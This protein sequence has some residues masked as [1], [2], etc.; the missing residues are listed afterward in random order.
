MA[1]AATRRPAAPRRRTRRKSNAGTG[2]DT[3]WVC[4][5]PQP[6]RA[7]PKAQTGRDLVAFFRASPLVGVELQIERDRPAG[8]EVDLY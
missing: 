6:D 7:V 5:V 4:G 8:R 2:G 3:N 1:K